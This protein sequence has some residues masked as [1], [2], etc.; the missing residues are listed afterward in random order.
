MNLGIYLND[1]LAGAEAGCRLLA[2]LARQ[3]PGGDL[4]RSLRDLLADVRSDKRVLQELT[5]SV[6][7]RTPMLKRAGGWIA[8][9]AARLKLSFRSEPDA[10]LSLFEGLELL[11]LGVLGKR[12]LW[13]ALHRVRECSPALL[14]VDL[15]ALAGRALAQYERLEAHRLLLAPAALVDRR[16]RWTLRDRA[17]AR[18]PQSYESRL[19][20]SASRDGRVTKDGDAEG[21]RSVPARTRTH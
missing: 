13:M 8:E 20:G 12:A 5:T 17:T 16:P 11:S 7:A 6:D 9:K 4:G 1:H 10:S 2:R 18:P 21:R 15:P 19:A 3:Y 14:R